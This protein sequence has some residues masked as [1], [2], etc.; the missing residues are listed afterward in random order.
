ML[1]RDGSNLSANNIGNQ[2]TVQQVYGGSTAIFYGLAYDQHFC[3]DK[4]ASSSD[5]WRRGM[6]LPPRLSTGS[7]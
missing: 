4:L 1:N 2:F 6:T 7:T 3:D 5:A